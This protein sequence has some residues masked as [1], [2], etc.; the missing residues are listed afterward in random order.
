MASLPL[1]DPDDLAYVI[2]TSGST[3]Q[4]KGVEIPH[5]ALANLL[6]AMARE[7]G[8]TAT[9]VLLAVTTLSFDI[10]ALELFL[11][12]IC[13]GTVVLATRKEAADPQ[14]L[15]TLLDTTG[16]TVMQATPATWRMLLEAGWAGTPG[17]KILCGGEALPRDLANRLLARA[18]EV[19]N[20]YGPTET[21]IWSSAGK[22]APGEG[23]ISIGRPIANTQMYVL[24]GHRNPLPAGVPGELYIGGTGLSP[25]YWNRPDLTAERFVPDPFSADPGARL[26]RTGD[27]ARW[28][29]DGT[30][31]CLGRVD[32]QVKVRGF[33]IE[34]GEIEAALER[35]PGV[36]QAVVVARAHGP[37]DTRLVGY[38]VGEAECRGEAL[39]A[40]LR[41]ILPE[42]MVP[43]RYVVLD[44]VPLTPNG[45]VDRN[46]LPDPDGTAGAD[47]YVGPRNPLEQTVAGVWADVLQVARV[48]VHDNFFALGGHSLLAV[49]LFAR[50]EKEIGRTLPLSMLFEAPT[51]EG[52]AHV[53]GAANKDA[54]P[55]RSLV[56]IRRAGQNV[57]IFGVHAGA[58]QVLFY[59][60]LA[61]ALGDDQPF[62]GLQA[63]V[64]LDGADAPYGSYRRIE[65]LAER[66]VSEVRRVRPRGPYVLAGSCAGGPIALEMAQ[67][68][69]AAGESVGPLLIFDSWLANTGGWVVGR[70]QRHWDALKKLSGGQRMWYVGRRAI[71]KVTW[72]LSQL[73]KRI[74]P[75]VIRAWCQARGQ[76][77]PQDV[78][79]KLFLHASM[80]LVATYQPRPFAGRVLLFR[81]TETDQQL[82]QLGKVYEHARTMGWGGLP[83]CEVEVVDMPGNHL[84]ALAESTV[85]EVARTIRDQLD[86]VLTGGASQVGHG[87]R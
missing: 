9:D 53:L 36:R 12:L 23:V 65:A 74:R 19:W 1:P 62:Y 33:R 86:H 20:V 43:A 51:V 37:G 46:A 76:K 84:D 69:Q 17:L 73:G 80:R 85:V 63:P 15:M 82:Q 41:G 79:D 24:D 47:E 38:V 50:L 71:G 44:R 81:S 56:A 2:Y 49:R 54:D 39:Q 72:R 61:R 78:I 29:P 31:E 32:H 67:R 42:Y 48:G 59:H 45:K 5:G 66:Y 57:P 8:F 75:H 26:Y 28:R 60:G 11:P 70:T 52:L 18:A 21:T 58:G 6:A 14:A 77:V 22:V 35:H 16:A 25:G 64:G 87:S 27:L 83:G 10:A 13:G 40:H 7:P 68:L 4:P 55:W 34:L 3:G 30:I